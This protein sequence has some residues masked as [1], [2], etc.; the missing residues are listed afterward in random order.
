M[1]STPRLP[2]Q[3]AEFCIE[4]LVGA[5]DG[6][7]LGHMPVPATVELRKVSVLISTF[8]EETPRIQEHK[9]MRRGFKRLSS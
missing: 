1:D 4:V 9:G 8:G 7:I 2:P 6:H 5:P 3:V